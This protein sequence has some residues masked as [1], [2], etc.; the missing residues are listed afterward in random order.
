MMSLVS[1]IFIYT[2]FDVEKSILP[3]YLQVNMQRHRLPVDNVLLLI[4]YCMAI[5]QITDNLSGV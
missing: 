4:K 2:I 1:T 3:H 5:M